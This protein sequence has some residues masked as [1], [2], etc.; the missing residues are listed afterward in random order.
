[1]RYV[2][3]ILLV[4]LLC[5]PVV[6]SEYIKSI[7]ESLGYIY[8][9][10]AWSSVYLMSSAIGAYLACRSVNAGKNLSAILISTLSACMVISALLALVMVDRNMYYSLIDFK[11]TWW[12]GFYTSIEILI[13]LIVGGNGLNYL[14]RMGGFTDCR[15]KT[16]VNPDLDHW[17]G[18]YK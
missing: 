5:K 17:T 18:K 15:V 16:P 7:I 2:F 13:A 11:S 9:I 14:A 4:S 8:Y 10:A 1:M 12:K 6:E 3:L